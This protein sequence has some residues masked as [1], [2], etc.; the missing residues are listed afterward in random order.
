MMDEGDETDTDMSVTQKLHDTGIGTPPS[1]GSDYS[2]GM[3]DLLG[4]TDEEFE[5]EIFDNEEDIEINQEDAW[6]VINA[7]FQEKKLV[8][9]Q[10]D[11]FNEFVRNTIQVTL[12]SF[13]VTFCPF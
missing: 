9:Q 4:G 11:S 5:Q 13:I 3:D 8:R 10:I 12:Y 6:V 7:Y 2:G 1:T